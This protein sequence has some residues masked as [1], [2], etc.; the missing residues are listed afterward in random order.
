[1]KAAMWIPVALLAGLVVGAWGPRVRLK[2][3]DSEVK[4]L[5][6]LLKDG[7]ASGRTVR[8]DGITRMLRI[9]DADG[10]SG[11]AP[12]TGPGGKTAENLPQ[13]DGGSTSTSE[14]ALATQDPPSGDD[15]I[16]EDDDPPRGRRDMT[17]R[18]DE[19]IELWQ[20][21]SD[22][23]RSTFISNAE[24]SPHDAAQ[25]DVLVEA[26]NMRL[27]ERIGT[28]AEQLKAEEFEMTEENGVRMMSDLS[29]VMVLTYDEMDRTMPE[30][31]RRGAGNE[32][33]LTDM[34]DPSVARPLIDVEGKLERRPRRR[35]LR[36]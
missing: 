5:E 30:D 6:Q 25:F 14:V 19:A 22:I 12:E 21:R 15:E 10:S 29:K 16:S 18:I 17:E 36:P 31:W 4:R 1:M 7:G 26:M 35:L 3:A 2:H 9:P 32:F 8:L 11:N 24:L 20:L 13:E 23:A 33:N 28:W 34:I 27:G